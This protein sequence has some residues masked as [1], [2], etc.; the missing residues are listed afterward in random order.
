MTAAEDPSSPREGPGPFVVLALALA[1]TLAAWAAGRALPGLP[2][3]DLGQVEAWIE[4]H[5]AVVAVAAVARIVALVVAIYLVATVGLALVARAARLRTLAA[6]V[7]RFS[8]PIVRRAVHGVAGMALT[9]G[10]AGGVAQASPAAP[11][12]MVALSRPPADVAVMRAVDDPPAPTAAGPTPESSVLATSTIAPGDH[13][14]GVAA[15]TLAAHRHRAPTD[16]EVAAYLVEIVAHNAPRL[17]VPD[18]PDLVFPGQVFELPAL[19]PE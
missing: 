6:L 11:P 12:T 17:A 5:G 2:A 15:R 9:I 10:V 14:W 8:L 3:G 19:D 7:D 1:A 4:R 16:D 18:H 13:L